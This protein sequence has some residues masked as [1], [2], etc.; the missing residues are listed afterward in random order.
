M[1]AW[2]RVWRIS[3]DSTG[4]TTKAQPQGSGI[5]VTVSNLLASMLIPKQKP[6]IYNTDLDVTRGNVN[7]GEA[8]EFACAPY[9]APQLSSIEM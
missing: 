6:K 8:D 2:L 1:H 9:L 5:S 4:G 7:D 3:T